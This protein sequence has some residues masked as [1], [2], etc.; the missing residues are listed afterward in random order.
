M[1]P[2]K[3][4]YYSCDC[5]GYTSS[6]YLSF[7]EIEAV[8]TGKDTSFCNTCAQLE[9]T[10]LNAEIRKNDLVSVG[11][12]SAAFLLAWAFVALVLYLTS[13]NVYIVCTGLMTAVVIFTSAGLLSSLKA[14]ALRFRRNRL[15][16]FINA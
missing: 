4:D 9:M 13:P 16:S 10:T 3:P 15:E 11:C 6:R 14:N 1:N 7:V 8:E 12:F 5:C 2:N